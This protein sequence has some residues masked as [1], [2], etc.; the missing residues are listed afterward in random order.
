MEDGWL[1][2]ERKLKK[3]KKIFLPPGNSGVSAVSIC[4]NLAGAG[5]EAGEESPRISLTH[6]FYFPYYP[7]S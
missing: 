4:N 6:P 5:K 2:S 1:L 7:F 3:R